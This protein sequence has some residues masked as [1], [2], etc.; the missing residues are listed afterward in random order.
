MSFGM[1]TRGGPDGN[2]FIYRNLCDLREGVNWDRP[3]EK[4]PAGNVL[5]NL[6]LVVHGREFLGSESVYFY[7]NLFVSPNQGGV[8][9]FGLQARNSATTSRWL[10]NNLLVY[11][12]TEK[13]GYPFRGWGDKLVSDVQVDGN[14]H[15]CPDPTAKAPTNFLAQCRA[16]DRGTFTNRYPH[17]WETHGQVGDPRFTA[18]NP[19]EGAANDYRL[20]TDSPAVGAGVVLPEF[21]PDVSRPEAGKTP[22][23]GPL[24][25]GTEDLRV[26]RFGR[27]SAARPVAR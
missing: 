5:S 23:I 20:R 22:D 27:F 7:H 3:D 19:E 8:L 10:L 18:F 12:P 15:W 21:L 26:G 2:I 17:A 11:L 25:L 9:A 14:V 4:N 16:T 1:N 6:P 24:P 13:R